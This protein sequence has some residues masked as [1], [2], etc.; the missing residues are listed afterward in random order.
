MS[1]RPAAGEEKSGIF[2]DRPA[3]PESNRQKA[4][5]RKLATEATE[6]TESK[7]IFSVS[8]S[9]ASVSSVASFLPSVFAVPAR[10]VW[11]ACLVVF[12]LR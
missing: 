4:K 1:V 5:T 9:V 8:P 6:H 7:R 3:E 12:Y 10:P 11:G 2:H